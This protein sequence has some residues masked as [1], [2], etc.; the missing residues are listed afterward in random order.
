[1]KHCT[2]ETDSIINDNGNTMWI[3]VHKC[4]QCFLPADV[5]IK[6]Q[7]TRQILSPGLKY[8]WLL[9]RSHLVLVFG[10]FSVSST[11]F[12]SISSFSLSK[13]TRWRRRDGGGRCRSKPLDD[14]RQSCILS[15]C[16]PPRMRSRSRSH[17]EIAFYRRRARRGAPSQPRLSAR[18]Q[19]AFPSIAVASRNARRWTHRPS[20]NIVTCRLSM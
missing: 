16:D 6:C 2:P 10:L 15:R 11:K 9:F 14:R 18:A 7:T 20:R 1:M 19:Q 12:K 8:R 3:S 5:S 13:K 4:P 17:A